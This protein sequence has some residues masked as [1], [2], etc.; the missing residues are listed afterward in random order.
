VAIVKIRI[1]ITSKHEKSILER[2]SF[3]DY[4]KGSKSHVEPL[5]KTE[6]PSHSVRYLVSPQNGILTSNELWNASCQYISL[7]WCVGLTA[8]PP[9]VSLLSRQCVILK[10]SQ[11]NRP[12]WPVTGD[13]FTLWRRSVLPVRYE[14]DCKYCYK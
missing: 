2:V 7:P 12:P 3:L 1:T 10:I 5:L 4:D 9:S 8:L 13:S 6:M 11:P 14:L